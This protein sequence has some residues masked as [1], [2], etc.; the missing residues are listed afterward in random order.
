MQGYADYSMM[1]PETGEPAAGICHA[2]GVNEGI[3][4]Q[5]LIYIQVADLDASM[6]A[7]RAGGGA[8]VHGPRDMGSY[9]HMCVIRDP[10][11]AVAALLGPRR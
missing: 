1:L 2:R 10:A 6:E 7:C 11:G 4:P 5:W 8:I 9:G 3:P